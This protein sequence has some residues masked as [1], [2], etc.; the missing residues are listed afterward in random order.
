MLIFFLADEAALEETS[1]SSSTS[2]YDKNRFET[3]KSHEKSSNDNSKHEDDYSF[4]S[5]SK[6][7]HDNDETLLNIDE[8]TPFDVLDTVKDDEPD[9]TYQREYE[10]EAFIPRTHI[11]DKFEEIPE[12]DDAEIADEEFDENYTPESN[13]ELESTSSKELFENYSEKPEEKVKSEISES[14]SESEPASTYIKELRAET[15]GAPSEYE[16]SPIELL[17]KEKIG[18]NEPIESSTVKVI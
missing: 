9:I 13:Q 18:R 10:H 5:E 2:S 11:G 6:P 3:V 15:T 1:V 14:T 16:L 4:T 7:F 17:K 8:V 12:E